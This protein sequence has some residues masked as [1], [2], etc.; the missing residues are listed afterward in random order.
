MPPG[1]IEDALRLINAYASAQ[2]EYISIEYLCRLISDVIAEEARRQGKTCKLLGKYFELVYGHALDELCNLSITEILEDNY[3]NEALREIVRPKTDYVIIYADG[4]DIGKLH[5]G[6]LPLTCDEYSE[7]L[8]TILKED[9]QVSGEVLDKLHRSYQMVTEIIKVL[10][11]APAGILTSPTYKA[12]L[13][14]AIMITALKDISSTEHDLHGMVI[15]SGGDD[16]ITLVPVDTMNRAFVYRENYEGDSYFHEIEGRPFA[17]AIPF[18]RSISVRR[19]VLFDVMSEEIEEV[20]RAMEKEAKTTIWINMRDHLEWR[21][22]TLIISS[23]RSKAKCYIPLSIGVTEGTMHRQLAKLFARVHTLTSLNI[24]SH[25]LPYDFEGMYGKV[26]EV[27]GKKP[28]TLGK[29]TEFI[30]KR[31]LR[32]EGELRNLLTERLLG[33]D[34]ELVSK[35]KIRELLTLIQRREKP[36]H[37]PLIYEIFNFI[38]LTR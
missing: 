19:V 5:Y 14:A 12:A 26:I 31:N 1:R 7:A 24:L 10:H 28:Y 4:D 38:K 8:L 30:V 9:A 15:Y 6:E 23:S 35:T 18:G 33:N 25:S 22:D 27:L 3:I 29:I 11:R 20:I 32:I 37:I 21:K 2:G 17:S 16:L 34:I 13:S 36:H